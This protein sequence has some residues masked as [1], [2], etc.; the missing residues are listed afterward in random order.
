MPAEAEAAK[1]PAA[2]KS[3]KKSKKK[4]GTNAAKAKKSKARKTTK[5]TAGAKA[6]KSAG[7]ATRSAKRKQ[8]LVI[9][10][11]P[12]KARTI[13]K[14]L[15][16]GYTVKASVGHVK[17]LVKSKLSV[18]I[19][20]DFAP[21]YEVIRGK[22][23]IIK[24]IK[25][26]ARDVEAVFLA[27]DPDRE[28]EAIAWHIAQELGKRHT[29]HIHRITF[30]EITKRAVQEAINNPQPLNQDKFESQQARRILDRIVGYQ[31]SPILWDKV[32]RGLSAGRVQSVAVRLIVEREAEIAAFVPE[33]YW[34]IECLLAG[35]APPPF[36][37]KVIRV[38]DDKFRPGSK[39]EVDVAL[40]ELGEAKFEVDT[41]KRR[42]RRRRPLAPLITSKLQQEASSRLRFTA[43]RTMMVA[44]QLY[45]GVEL[46]DEGSVALITY[47]RTD[48]TRVS[49]EA[50][51]WV[52]EHIEAKFGKQYL[53][54]EPNV[55]K[56]KKGA[57][58]AHEAIR[59]T[60][61][62]YP[63]KKVARFLSKD[64]LKLYTLI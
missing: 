26:A 58:D 13:R 4:A 39:E 59:P 16:P 34:V 28:G 2:K 20:N 38:D 12:A 54:A 43:K 30:N 49:N 44:Q 36:L 42:E 50:L 25:D 19:D 6:P 41:I 7:S 1:R 11:S 9:V 45:E 48:S 63:P 3:K 10:E 52:R 55:Y 53:P 56:T 64:Q 22:A 37:A 35:S 27:P 32:R 33:E 60:S 61:P 23:K 31:I 14:Y 17:D 51:D 21:H 5:S 47:M 40:K 24:E 46:G 29:G 15:G 8:S 18:D 57:Q 62:D